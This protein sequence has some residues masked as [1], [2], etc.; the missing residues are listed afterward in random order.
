[1][2]QAHRREYFRAYYRRTAEKRR[3]IARR[4]RA[5]ARVRKWCEDL[6]IVYTKPGEA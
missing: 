4:S 1:M 6:G 5:E 3:E 2:S